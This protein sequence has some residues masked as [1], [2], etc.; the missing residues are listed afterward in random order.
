MSEQPH[1]REYQPPVI[2]PIRRYYFDVDRT[3]DDVQKTVMAMSRLIDSLP[4]EIDANLDDIMRNNRVPLDWEYDYDPRIAKEK[5]AIVPLLVVGPQLDN[6]SIPVD[7]LRQWYDDLLRGMQALT[8]DAHDERCLK[9]ES[10]WH[11]LCDSSTEC[12]IRIA[13]QYLIHD[14]VMPNFTNKMYQDDHKRAF[15]VATTKLSVCTQQGLLQPET[16][17]SILEEYKKKYIRY[18]VPMQLNSLEQV[19][20]R[21]SP[22]EE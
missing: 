18:S 16:R 11:F 15:Q 1:E 12:P 10:G 8:K 19:N 6:S 5:L 13:K 2:S 21:H 4:S 22:K 9:F 20:G 14:T 7:E 3:V 17:V